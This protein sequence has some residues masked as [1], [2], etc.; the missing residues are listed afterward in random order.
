MKNNFFLLISL[1][2]VQS[3]FQYKT[4][5]SNMIESVSYSDAVVN[6]AEIDEEEY[7]KATYVS[8]VSKVKNLRNS[9]KSTVEEI[10]SK[11]EYYDGLNNLI[12]NRVNLCG[13]YTTQPEACKK[14][15]NCGWCQSSKSCIPGSSDGPLKPCQL[16]AFQF[17]APSKDF[18]PFNKDQ[19]VVTNKHV[20]DGKE[21]ITIHPVS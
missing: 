21:I 7:K 9:E 14:K 18:N 5:E 15:E 13:E 10:K 11:T 1:L 2:V 3:A 19:K 16:G 12:V 8:D 17:S 6:N 4:T 20:V